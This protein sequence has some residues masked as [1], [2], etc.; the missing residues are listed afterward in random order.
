[1]NESEARMYNQAIIFAAEAH[2]GQFRKY[3]G[4]PYV[5]HPLEVAEILRRHDRPINEIIGG[6]LHD[7]V[8]DTNRTL[9]QVKFH[10]GAE[11]GDLVNGVTNVATDK[12][13]PRVERFW[14]NVAHLSEQTE[15]SHNIKCAD[16]ISNMKN[17][18]N[19][20]EHSLVN[21]SAEKMIVLDHLYLADSNLIMEAQ[22]V[23]T[24]NLFG[25]HAEY[26]HR[27]GEIESARPLAVR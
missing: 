16:I 4:E 23:I 19:A 7:V 9:K 24:N 3:T 11:V 14:Q 1:M 18:P 2:S 15:G 13:V 17:F 25:Y 26:T 5:L 22:Q 27:R 6:I 12:K 10:F 21:Y 8:E 20:D